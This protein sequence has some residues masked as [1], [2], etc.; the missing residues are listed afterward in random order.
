M[1][2]VGHIG[3]CVSQKIPPEVFLHFFPNGWE[4]L[5]QILHGYYTFLSMLD[6]RKHR[7]G[8]FF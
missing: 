2:F 6:Y 5:V 4:F 7:G 3:F 8:V 1:Y